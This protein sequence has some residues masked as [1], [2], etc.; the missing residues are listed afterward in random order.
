MTEQNSPYNP[1]MAAY[2]IDLAL[3]VEAQSSWETGE[4]DGAGLENPFAIPLACYET[5]FSTTVSRAEAVKANV[6]GPIQ[7]QYELVGSIRRGNKPVADY[8]DARH[9]ALNL[10]DMQDFDAVLRLIKIYQRRVSET[11]TNTV[12]Y[13]L[14]NLLMGFALRSKVDG[15]GVIVL[16][17]TMQMEEWL[18]NVYYQMTPFMPS[19]EQVYGQVHTGFRNMYKGFRGRYRELAA[20]FDPD[21]PLYLV[22]RSLGA[23][24]TSIGALDIALQQPERARNIHAY[25]FASSRVGDAVFTEQ[26]NRHVGT[27]YRIV[28]LCDL[29]PTIPFA[30]MSNVARVPSYPYADTKGEV[31][32]VCQM[33][34]L[35][36]NHIA[37][38]H[39]ATHDYHEVGVEDARGPVWFVKN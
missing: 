11:I 7:D 39:V 37:A 34:N 15:H 16:R 30:E 13:T 25:M 5:L 32:F 27:S 35:I 24:V 14:S 20:G 6:E 26:H 29:V 23:A 28:N 18:T 31:A 8:E 33:G 2:F 22:G 21:K 17:G 19:K 36:A 12:R 1:E 3:A 10:M 38:Y 4:L 9:H